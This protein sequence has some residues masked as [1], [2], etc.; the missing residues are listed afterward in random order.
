M[1]G[2]SSENAVVHHNRGYK[3]TFVYLDKQ[4]SKAPSAKRMDQLKNDN[5]VAEITFTRNHPASHIGRLLIAN[6]PSLFGIDL[7]R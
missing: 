6:F 4:E 2:E 7:K 1:E 5:R 3:R